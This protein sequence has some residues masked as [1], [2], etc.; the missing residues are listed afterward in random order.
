MREL[1]KLR[2]R[3]L[4]S[5]QGSWLTIM[6]DKPERADIKGN[7]DDPEQP[8]GSGRGN[9]IVHEVGEDGGEEKMK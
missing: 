7:G 3:G 2:D 9:Q 5:V 1:W 6:R 8:T 4:W